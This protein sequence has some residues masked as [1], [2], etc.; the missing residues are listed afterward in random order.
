MTCA[1]V[2]VLVQCWSMTNIQK[3]SPHKGYRYI[4][5]SMLVCWSF[6]AFF[7][8]YPFFHEN[9]PRNDQQTNRP[10]LGQNSLGPFP[11][12]RV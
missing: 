12:Q 1:N 9:G 11:A 10:T 2:G 6:W 5:V 8:S 3:L 4:Y 7:F